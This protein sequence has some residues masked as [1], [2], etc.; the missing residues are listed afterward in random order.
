MN[1]SLKSHKLEVVAIFWWNDDHTKFSG[2]SRAD[3]NAISRYLDV[4]G[5][6]Q[7]SSGSLP[8]AP[9]ALRNGHSVLLP[10][11]HYGATAKKVIQFH[12]DTY[13]EHQELGTI[14]RPSQTQPF[15]VPSL[16]SQEPYAPEN[17][18]SRQNEVY[19]SCQSANDDR[20]RVP[21]FL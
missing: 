11:A 7:Q 4:Q 19:R 16:G 21:S 5:R 9:N 6:H 1:D 14:H 10:K 15:L 13:T 3:P 18:G 2:S 20:K 8:T 17:S 12:E